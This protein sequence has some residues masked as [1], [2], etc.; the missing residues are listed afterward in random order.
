MRKIIKIARK[1]LGRFF[2]LLEDKVNFVRYKLGGKTYSQE[3]EDVILARLFEG[4]RLGFYVDV[5]AHHPYRFS[6]TY[7]FYSKKWHGINIDAMP[8][9][10]RIFNRFRKRDI[11][12]E[13]GILSNKDR[14]PFYIFDEPALNGFWPSR[15]IAL[16]TNPGYQ[17][18]DEARIQ[19]CP[20]KEI[21]EEYLPSGQDI[22][23]LSIDAEGRDYEVVLSND[24]ERFRPKV[25]LIEVFGK[26][27]SE[28]MAAPVC[29]FLIEKNYI[30]Y[31]KTFNSVFFLEEKFK[32]QLL[33]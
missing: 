17:I 33:R 1:C 14:I 7:F 11:N 25:V 30:P 26:D 19:T 32:K 3:G 21:L 24:W 13:V 31:S 15:K 28:L 8:G 23:F 18:I 16:E 27:L 2:P 22:D 9:S 10:M 6:N 5:G 12:L 4:Q 20:L 29:L